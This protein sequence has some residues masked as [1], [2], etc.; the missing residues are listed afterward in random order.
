MMKL[1]AIAPFL[2]MPTAA[3]SQG[4]PYKLLI[5]DRSGGMAVTEYPSKARCERA[6]REIEAIVAEQNSQP[7]TQLPSGGV[8]MPQRLYLRATCISG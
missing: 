2:L 7:S 6:V 1:L 4:L 3:W 5:L 8:I